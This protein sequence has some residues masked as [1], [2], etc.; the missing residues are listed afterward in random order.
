LNQQWW[1][2]RGR[3]V[4][5]HRLCLD[6]HNKHRKKKG[7]KVQIWECHDKPNQQWRLQTHRFEYPRK[8]W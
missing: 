6:V 8:T 4:N 1:F 3:L 5:G 7:G 2:D